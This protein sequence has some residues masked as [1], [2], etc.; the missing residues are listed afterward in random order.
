MIIYGYETYNHKNQLVQ[1][2]LIVGRATRDGELI[3]PEGNKTPYGLARIPATRHADGSED[4]WNI[5]CWDKTGSNIL[6]NL[7]ESEMLCAVGRIEE[8][9]RGE[10]VY[11]NLIADF[12]WTYS[13]TTR[14]PNPNKGLLRPINID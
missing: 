6:A 9:H 7:K 4:Y 1:T 5:K 12:V 11:R 3:Q 14:K 13:N 10:T 2:A 8:K